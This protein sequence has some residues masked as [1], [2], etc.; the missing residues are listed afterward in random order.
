MMKYFQAHIF[1]L[2][3]WVALLLLQACYSSED[4]ISSIL[5]RADSLMQS[6]ADSALSLLEAIPSPEAL[7]REQSA[8]Y[9]LLLTQAQDKTY[10]VHTD[11][12]LIRAASN[13]YDSTHKIALQ[14]KAH[15]Y[16]ARVYQDN[17]NIPACVREYLTAVSKAEKAEENQIACLAY[18]NLARIFYFEGLNLKA[19]SCY[20]EAEKLSIQLND[21]IRWA[22]VLAHRGENYLALGMEKYDKVKS[23]LNLAIKLSKI[24]GQKSIERAASVSLSS[25][26]S[27]LDSAE[28][29]VHYARTAISLNKNKPYYGGFLLLGDAFYQLG[30]YDSAKV[31]LTKSLATGLAYTKVGAYMRLSEIAEIEGRLKEAVRFK[32]SLS[33]Y[34][35]SVRLNQQNVAIVSAIK[36]MDISEMHQKQIRYFGRFSY[37]LVAISMV[38]IVFIL[39]F[40]YKRKKY[41]QVVWSNEVEH[42]RLKTQLRGELEQKCLEIEQLQYALKQIEVSNEQTYFLRSQ[43]ELLENDKKQIFRSLF[44]H[45]DIYQKMQ[46]IIHYYKKY[47]DYKERFE[48]EDWLRLIASIDSSAQF[49][50]SLLYHNQSLVDDDIYLCYLLKMDLPVIDISIILG[51]TRDNIYKK[52]KA[53]AAK[54]S[55]FTESKD[56]TTILNEI[57]PSL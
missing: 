36:D 52:K 16:W 15:Y 3:C 31:Y 14:A 45:A 5:N 26:Y 25:L 57:Y 38:L 19:D 39:F 32:D 20:L 4:H 50:K 29:A 49:K 23:K 17:K 53:I 42:E 7:P 8:Y 51:C 28:L 44:Q 56:L 41:R 30:E 33:R 1:S 40:F 48:Q 34:Q 18:A 10:I 24:L 22:W 2:L 21:T 37:S 27:R 11:D 12:S 13:Y 46:R 9:G 35:D 47:N 6:Q 43:I 54:L 55:S